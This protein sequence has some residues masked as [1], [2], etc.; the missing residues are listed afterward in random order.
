MM[1]TL[2][3]SLLVTATG[4]SALDV[5]DAAPDL[6]KAAWQGTPPTLAG[7]VVIVQLWASW[8][9][10]CRKAIPKLAELAAKH[11]QVVVLVGLSG[12][13]AD[14]VAAYANDAANHLTYPVAA[15]SAADYDLWM[16]GATGV[17]RV[18]LLD[19]SSAVVWSGL[20]DE[21]IHPLDSVLA[22]TWNLETAKRLAVLEPRLRTA[23]STYDGDTS[24]A[25]S[26]DRV[27][28]LAEEVLTLDPVHEQAF[29]CLTHLARKQDDPVAFRACYERLPHGRVD[30]ARLNNLAWGLLTKG[31]DLQFI[32]PDVALT[33]TDA[34]IAQKPDDADLFD[35]RARAHYLLADLD[36]AIAD[37]MKATALSPGTTSLQVTLDYYSRLKATRTSAK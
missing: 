37:Q 11:P 2:F 30:I 7:H 34:A 13:S 26:A 28:S 3:L 21:V 6:A 5:G 12:E 35:T 10:P 29:N 20:P 36:L 14:T 33:L 18:L 32:L 27:K 23:I 16:D 22:G 4:L 15:L 19:R 24:D 8:N 17:P 25:D 31:T 9:P 1:R